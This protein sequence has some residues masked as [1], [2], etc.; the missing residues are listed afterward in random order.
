MLNFSNKRSKFSDIE[1]ERGY[2]SVGYRTTCHNIIIRGT[3]GFISYNR[4]H[5]T[6]WTYK[7]KVIYC[8]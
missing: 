5:R 2:I 7:M 3:A 6:I 1:E 4:P 8:H